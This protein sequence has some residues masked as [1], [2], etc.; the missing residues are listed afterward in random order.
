MKF[1]YKP[2][3]VEKVDK[4]V[5]PFLILEEA[6]PKFMILEATPNNNLQSHITRKGALLKDVLVLS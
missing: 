2:K 4:K 1:N 5:N 6:R 3:F